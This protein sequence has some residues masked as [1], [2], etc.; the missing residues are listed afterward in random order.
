MAEVTGDIGGQPVQLNNAATETTLKQLLAAMLA[1]AKAQGMD[2]SAQKELEKQ[3]KKLSKETEKQIKA[4]KEKTE[5]DKKATQAEKDKA[6]AAERAKK[7]Q[8][9]YIESLKETEEALGK[10]SQ[11][12]QDAAGAVTD[13]TKSVASMGNSATAAAAMFGK[14]PIVGGLVANVFGGIAEAGEKTYKAFQQASTVG[15]NFGGSINEMIGA[16][17]QAGMT[18]EGFTALVAKNGQNLALLGGSTAEGARRLAQFG[19][20]IR[21]NTALNAELANLGYSTEDINNGLAR[22]SAIMAKSGRSQSDVNKNLVNETG[23]YLKNLDAVSKLTG[24]TK[25][26][27]Q[28]EEDARRNDAQFRIAERKLD[29]NSRKELELLMN[30]MSKAEQEA[31]K[32]ALATGTMNEAMVKL[33][34]TSPQV[35]SEMMKTALAARSSGQLTRDSALQLDRNMTAAAKAAQNNS[36]LNVLG[37]N[38]AADYND[39]VISTLDRAARTSTLEEQ[40]AKNA[41]E[42]EK[43]QKSGMTPEQMKAFQENLAELS[44]RFN[45]LL[46]ENMPKFMSVMD[47]V[48]RLIEGPLVTA[49]TTLID[50]LGKIVVGLVALKVAQV[51]YQNKL[52]VEQLKAAQRGTSKDP[53]FVKDVAGGPLGGGGDKL[54]GG[55]G[56]KGGKGIGKYVKGAGAIGAVVAVA[57]LASDLSDISSK[58]KSGELTKEEAQEARG[59]AVGGAAG[60]AGGAMAGAA[61]GAAIG[62]VIPIIGTAVGGMLGGAIGYFV[63]NKAGEAA[64]KAIAKPVSGLEK[65]TKAQTDATKTNTEATEKQAEAAKK[66]TEAA[67]KKPAGPDWT[68][69]A[70]TLRYF[71]ETMKQPGTGSTPS[72][73]AAALAQHGG[74]QAGVAAQPVKNFDALQKQLASQGITD[75]KAVSNIMA[76]VQA[77]S[78]GVS[79]SENLNY[80]GAKLF[81]LYGAGNKGGNKVRFKTMEEANAVAA[82]GPEAVGNMIYGGRMGNAADEGFKYRGRGLIQL[83]GKDNYAKFGK[84]IGVDL[85][86]NPDLANDP[87]VAQQ[88]AA[89]YFAD[90][91]KKGV[92]LSNI[93]AIGKAVGYAGG[94]AETAKRAQIAAGFQTQMAGGGVPSPAAT[95]TRSV[96]PAAQTVQTTLAKPPE[97]Q[98][99]VSQRPTMGQTTPAGAPKPIQETAET[100]LASLNS[101]MD[102]LIA[103]NQKT[104]QSAERQV[105]VTSA[106]SADMMVSA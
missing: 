20:E 61:A 50:N 27:L 7:A 70:S 31:F 36:S 25:E 23:E 54:D 16:A 48:S 98:P 13:L 89:A 32:G 9:K 93:E 44:N 73:P 24:K 92:D 11:I 8:E 42:K 100:L 2:A 105:R 29:A 97:A 87:Q 1:M 75:P 57:E 76:Q 22:Y 68:D 62:S 39:Q 82:K 28:Q 56:G 51:A 17:S 26:A 91:Q 58:E 71:R 102:M 94:A 45:K 43:A 38:L 81:E 72:G 106:L 67:A 101:K 15:A 46:A 53:M 96:T 40:I 69:P 104:S 55:K 4:T 6:A 14:I 18:I 65:A 21:K 77:E 99:Q 19:K 103:I 5:V 35:A 78:G 10:V 37:A 49:F 83:T 84:M 12:I 95:A 80:S 63:G 86:T 52:K 34:A 74:G 88:I 90:K 3:L 59:G 66:A 41:A 60:G 30:S 85:V 47:S 64:G 33:N 79:K